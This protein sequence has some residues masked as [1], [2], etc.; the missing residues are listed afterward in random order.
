MALALLVAGP[1][2]GVLAQR[3]GLRYVAAA[4]LTLVAIALTVFATTTPNDGYGRVL[5]VIVLLGAGAGFVITATSDSIVGSL[6]ERDLGVGS[7]TNSTA[8]QF[9]AALGVAVTGSLPAGRY[10][11]ELARC[12]ARHRPTAARASGSRGRPGR[13]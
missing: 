8:I 5:A 12:G 9:G 4:G 10:R 6:P 3:L 2:A 13:A 11:S 1:V 7:A